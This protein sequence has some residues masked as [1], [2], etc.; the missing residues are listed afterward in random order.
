MPIPARSLHGRRRRSRYAWAAAV[1]LSALVGQAGAAPA[2]PAVDPAAAHRAQL[3]SPSNPTGVGL[4]GEYFAAADLTGPVLL[5]RVDAVLDLDAGLDWPVDRSSR[6]PKSARWTGWIKVPF[7]GRY[8]FDAE[9]ATAVVTVGVTR[10]QG[11]GVGPAVALDLE[12]GRFYPVEVVVA[13][14]PDAR[15][16]DRIAL[17]WTA[18]HGARY[19]IP[20]NL[21]FLPSDTVKPSRP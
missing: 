20:R 8:R 13:R 12:P 18:P 16:T 3:C 11:P 15:S 10:V 5:S 9:P 4:R 21:L 1:A 19:V 17:R 2:A 14:L 6:R 7:A